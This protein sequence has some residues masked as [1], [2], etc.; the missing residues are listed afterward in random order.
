MSETLS[1]HTCAPKKCTM[2][3]SKRNRYSSKT[4][5]YR[6]KHFW[7]WVKTIVMKHYS[8]RTF[9]VIP[10]NRDDCQ[11][12]DADTEIILN[13]ESVTTAIVVFANF[14]D[15]IISGTNRNSP[16]TQKVTYFRVLIPP[17]L[18]PSLFLY[19]PSSSALLI[20]KKHIDF[21]GQRQFE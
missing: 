5:F 18:L 17:L 16:S 12:I 2:I 19:I 1:Y 14:F 15:I 8:F 9:R 11:Y 13:A 3:S 21:D 4:R 7:F 10:A 6:C 20:D